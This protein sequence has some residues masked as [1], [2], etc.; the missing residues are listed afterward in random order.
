M[1][2]FS[3]LFQNRSLLWLIF[4]QS[5]S[6]KSPLFCIVLHS[7]SHWIFHC[8]CSSEN[9]HS[10]YQFMRLAIPSTSKLSPSHVKLYPNHSI[11]FY[12]TFDHS[13]KKS[14]RK[15]CIRWK[16]DF[17]RCSSEGTY[18]LFWRMKFQHYFRLPPH[19]LC[20]T[21]LGTL[22]EQ[23]NSINVVLCL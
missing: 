7:F 3:K 11:K 17:M 8:V 14:D 2:F 21:S 12:C 13:K 6:P 16:V 23:S 5:H 9:K 15:V 20:S 10:E 22:T 18:E 19:L 1:E 4:F